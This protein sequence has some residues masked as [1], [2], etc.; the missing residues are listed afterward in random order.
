[1]NI[2]QNR[3]KISKNSSDK[4]SLW[5]LYILI[6]IGYVLSFSIGSTKIGRIYNWDMFFAIGI[7]L[8]F[9]GTIY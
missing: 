4:G 1:M 2:K 8:I 5:L 9:I 3:I 6:T 7:I